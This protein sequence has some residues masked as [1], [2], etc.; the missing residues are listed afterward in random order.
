LLPEPTKP[1]YDYRFSRISES[2]TKSVGKLL[3][4]GWKYVEAMEEVA[5]RLS[6]DDEIRDLH[7]KAVQ[8][9]GRLRT[10][11]AGFTHVVVAESHVKEL[12]AWLKDWPSK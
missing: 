12:D 9:G 5:G 6:P 10:V 1:G 11:V 8:N 7:S 2:D 3:Q 4:Q